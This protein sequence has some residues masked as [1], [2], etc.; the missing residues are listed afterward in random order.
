[1]PISLQRFN[2]GYR[3]KLGQ[4]PERVIEVLRKSG[5]ACTAEEM[6]AELLGVTG[7]YRRILSPEVKEAA[8]VVEEAAE[9]LVKQGTL[10]SLSETDSAGLMKTYYALV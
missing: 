6:A 5:Q 3:A 2:E 10:R 9:L 8:I 7:R 4:L 1:M